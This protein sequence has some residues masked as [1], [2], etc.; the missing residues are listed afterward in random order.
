[1]RNASFLA[2]GILLILVQSNLYR[3]LGSFHLHGATPSLI[4]PVVI[5]L[6]VH[7][8]SMA[9]GASLCFVLGYLLDL[10]ASAPVGLFTFTFVAIWW[11]SRIAGVRLT[12]QTA[13]TRMSM[14][15]GFSLV[16]SVIILMLL[17]VF[18]ADNRRPLEVGSVVLPHALATALVSPLIFRLA[19]WL[20]QSTLT[21][22]STEGQR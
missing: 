19:Q 10:F 7:E 21:V 20:H 17:A 13:L 9:R 15:L 8:Q 14:A 1:M 2:V 5:F 4:L 18:G 12:A 6:G 16:E 22:R 3:L 11:L